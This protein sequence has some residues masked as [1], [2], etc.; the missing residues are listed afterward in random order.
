MGDDDESTVNTIIAYRQI[1]AGWVEKHQGRVVD[2]PADNVLADFGSAPNAVNSSIDI[3]RQL[4]AENGRL[5]DN[6]TMAILYG[7][8]GRVQEAR[9]MLD[10]GAEGWSDT[11]KN[12]RFLMTLWPFKDLQA[13]GP[14]L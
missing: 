12:V 4:E 9:T 13:M 10:K 2:S 1:I 5:P 14:S 8:V 3:Q 6:R 7:Q 11:M